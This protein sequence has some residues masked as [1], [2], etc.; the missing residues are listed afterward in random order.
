VSDPATSG[1][2]TEKG[3]RWAKLS[4]RAVVDRR[5][6]A[7]DVRVLAFI[8]IHADRKGIGWPSQMLGAVALGLSR[9]TVCRSIKRLRE[10]GYLDRYRKRTPC[11]HYRNVYRL[12][13]PAYVPIR[14]QPTDPNCEPAVT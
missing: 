12:Q 14:F 7:T 11:G 2:A 9:E 5:L 8:A 13:Y 6:Q 1:T 10:T 3:G 4:A